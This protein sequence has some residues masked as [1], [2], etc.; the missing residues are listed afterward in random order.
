MA[1]IG[2][3]L[4]GTK[5]QTVVVDDSFNVLASDRRPTPKDKGPQGVIDA[6]IESAH[7]VIASA[8]DVAISGLGLGSPGYIDSAEGT[9]SHAGNLPDWMGT[10]QVAA[11]LQQEFH[12]PVAIINDVQ[13]AVIAE[14]RLGA[15]KGVSS[16]LGVF[17]GTG[18]GGGIIINGELWR[19]RDGAGEIGHTS[20][21]PGGRLCGCG[22]HGCLEAYSGR[23]AME[24]HARKLVTEGEH[25]DLFAIMEAKGRP[26][27][28]SG[29]WQKAL[30][31]KDKMARALIDRSVEALGVAIANA[32]NLLDVPVVVIG[33]G[34]GCRFGQP[35]ADRIAA[36]MQPGLLF[37]ERPPQV[38]TAQ[39]ADLGGAIGASL[40]LEA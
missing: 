18:V 16:M 26:N 19:G 25:T 29:I 30:N 20:V 4:G 31:D 7:A 3:D 14:S 15:G 1:R 13:A 8:G 34:L 35:F 36:A 6:I 11:P 40:A 28:T 5:I 10:V 24:A 12:V 2:V 27:L 23:A 22:R 38:V 33:G 39:L 32:M 17:V 21:K 9:V 37:P